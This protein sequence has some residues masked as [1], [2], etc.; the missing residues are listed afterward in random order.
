MANYAIIRVAKIKNMPNLMQSAMHNNR[1]HDN[2]PNADPKLTKNN[3]IEFGAMDAKAVTEAVKVKLEEV[4]KETGRKNRKDAVITQ[5]YLLNASP[6][7]F[8]TLSPTTEKKWI[9]KNIQFLKNKYGEENLIQVVAHRDESHLHLQAFVVPVLRDDIGT[10]LSA[11]GYTG[12]KALLRQ[13]QT[14]YAEDM[15]EFGLKRGRGYNVEMDYKEL[16]EYKEELREKIEKAKEEAGKVKFTVLNYKP[17]IEKLA[18]EKTLLQ[19]ENKKIEQHTKYLEKKLE[20]L[21]NVIEL[22][23][24]GKI[25][26]QQIK[27]AQIQEKYG[28]GEYTNNLIEQAKTPKTKPRATREKNFEEI[29]E[30]QE[31]KNMRKFEENLIN[32]IKKLPIETYLKAI[33]GITKGVKH[34]SETY[35]KSPFRDE[36][37]ESFAVDEK[38]NT[39]Y[40]FG[41]EKG[42]D[43][44]QLDMELKKR[45]FVESVKSLSTAVLG[46]Y[47][48]PTPPDDEKQNFVY[49][50]TKKKTTEIESV[51]E[52]Q[53]KALLRLLNERCINVEVSSKVLKEVAYKHGK[54]H[55]YGL[56]IKCDNDTYSTFNAYGK[57][58]TGEADITTIK[59]EKE[60]T[61]VAVFEGM[62]DYFARLSE[63]HPTKI[64]AHIIIMHGAS[65]TEKTIAKIKELKAENVYLYKH[66]DTAG[67]RVLEKMEAEFSEKINITDMSEK[68]RDFNDYNE[69]TIFEN[70]QKQQKEIRKG[71]DFG[72]S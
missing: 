4:E 32:D 13:L 58:K 18:E 1:E 16:N 11:K 68:Y 7:F 66:N 39:W 70:E 28:R 62:T 50:D 52:I 2:T 56:G 34:G 46:Q 25:T 37:T 69:K 42:G 9:A 63:M 10:R 12:T 48:S 45:S 15:K 35:Y 22:V 26:P 40:D 54:N 30:Q 21:D 5:E 23:K 61:N 53:N 33:A 51:K 29:I 71:Y 55:Y 17:V 8:E 3:T 14:E 60:T 49:E 57:F 6:E 24:E 65:N 64:S 59:A 31:S 47:L 36:K 67:K 44:I 41:I 19:Q 38:T 43:L 27:D 20:K 72:M